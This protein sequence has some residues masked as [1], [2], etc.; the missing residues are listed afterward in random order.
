QDRSPGRSFHCLRCGP[1]GHRA[2]GCSA[3]PGRPPGRGRP[4]GLPGEWFRRNPG[5]GWPWAPAAADPRRSLRPPWASSAARPAASAR[6]S[7]NA[8]RCRRRCSPEERPAPPGPRAA[9]RPWRRS[10][11]IRGAE[12]R[13]RS[14]RGRRSGPVRTVEAYAVPLTCVSGLRGFRLLG[15]RRVLGRVAVLVAVGLRPVVLAAPVVET[16][17]RAGGRTRRR[18][19]RRGRLRVRGVRVRAVRREGVVLRRLAGGR[20][21]AAVVGRLLPGVV[22]LLIAGVVRLLVVA[23][24]LLRLLVRAGLLVAVAAVVVA[25]RPVVALAGVVALRSGELPGALV[26]LLRGR[27]GRLLRSLQG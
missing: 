2:A 19:V 4:G 27:A 3:C 25:L 22:G 17:E 21:V 10:R 13:R 9:R 24:R 23:G 14:A 18:P 8:S 26:L 1:V 12:A 11:W 20:V 5:P 15:I 6:R 16:G 7:P